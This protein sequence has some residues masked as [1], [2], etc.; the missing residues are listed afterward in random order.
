MYYMIT[1][2]T[3]TPGTG[4]STLGNKLAVELG[5]EYIDANIIIDKYDLKDDYDEEMDSSVVDIKELESAIFKEIEKLKSDNNKANFIIDSHMS[6][7]FSNKKI[8][9]CIVCVCELGELKKRLTKRKYKE[10]KIK[11]NMD[12][13]I[14]ETCLIEAQENN[15]NVLK[16]DN[17]TNIKDTI[18]KIKALM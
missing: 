10:S 15:H 3:G 11:A 14:F 1:S 8:D 4:K 5:F 9:L 13:E 2:I 7:H 6:H 18:K 16:V 17:N 12:V